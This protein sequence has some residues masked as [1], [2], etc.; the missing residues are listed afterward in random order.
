MSIEISWRSKTR[1]DRR[2]VVGQWHHTRRSV[3]HVDPAV[4]PRNEELED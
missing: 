1:R 2:V 3:E 4:E